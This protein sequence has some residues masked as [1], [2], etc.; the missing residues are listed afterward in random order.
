M[1]TQQVDSETR[2][3]DNG[4]MDDPQ[5]ES[6]KLVFRTSPDLRDLAEQAARYE[7]LTLSSYMRRLLVLDL[8]SRGLLG[9]AD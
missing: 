3:S 1:L 2:L 9:D 7:G 8:R 5:T 6:V 4:R